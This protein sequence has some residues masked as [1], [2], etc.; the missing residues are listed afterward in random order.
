MIVRIEISMEI[1][2]LFFHQHTLSLN[3]LVRYLSHSVSC[4][5]VLCIRL[6]TG[7]PAY[8]K[9]LALVDLQGKKP[10][11]LIEVFLEF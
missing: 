8:V 9:M 6:I 10:L 4:Q 11:M 2:L 5:N 3:N 7:L 1:D